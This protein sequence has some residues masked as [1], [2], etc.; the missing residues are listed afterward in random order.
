M[1]LGGREQPR[2]PSGRCTHAQ[3]SL[4][5]LSPCP[6][7][8]GKCEV[9]AEDGD[10]APDRG[11]CCRCRRVSGAAARPAGKCCVRCPRVHR[12]SAWT[13]CT[14]RTSAAP[15]AK[16]VGACAV[17]PARHHDARVPERLPWMQE[18]RHDGMQD[19]IKNRM[20][21]GMLV[22]FDICIHAL[23]RESWP[24]GPQGTHGSWVP[25]RPALSSVSV[26]CFKGIKVFGGKFNFHSRG[27][28]LTL[29]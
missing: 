21:A 26:P 20:Q 19:R 11:L 25:V 4:P 23:A 2:S 3:G 6:H 9:S 29:I 7:G 10:A 18:E 15:S 27:K 8:L 16:T 17:G 13:P 22:N 5:N 28:S 12:P 24:S 1:E 14:S